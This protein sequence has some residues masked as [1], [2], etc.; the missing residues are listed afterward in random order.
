MKII[1]VINSGDEAIDVNVKVKF[2]GAY[3]NI[4]N[5]VDIKQD[6]ETD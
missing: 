2:S 6:K 5:H 4:L 1:T 3:V